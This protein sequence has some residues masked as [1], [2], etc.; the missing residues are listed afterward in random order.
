MVGVLLSIII[1]IH[2]GTNGYRNIVKLIVFTIVAIFG[3][4][5]QKGRYIELIGFT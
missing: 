2:N 1:N 5:T 3:S 4:A